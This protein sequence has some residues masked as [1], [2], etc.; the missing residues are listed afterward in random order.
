MSTNPYLAQL[1]GQ[2]AG[3]E[4]V[5][6][7]AF[8]KQANDEGLDLTRLPDEEVADLYENVFKPAKI[9]ELTQ[10]DATSDGLIEKA[11]SEGAS[12]EVLERLALAKLSGQAM[13]EGY[14]E[15]WEKFA[16]DAAAAEAAPEEAA[17]EGEG[18]GEEGVTEEEAKAIVDEAAEEAVEEAAAQAPADAAPEEVAAAAAEMV[19][20]KVEEKT[21]ELLMWKEAQK[22]GGKPGFLSR[23]GKKTYR[24]V[25]RP[26][27]RHIARHKLPYG[28]GAAAAGGL[29]AGYFG[30]KALQ[31]KGE[32][33]LSITDVV[34]VAAY[35]DY[36]LADPAEVEEFL[37]EAQKKGGKPGFLRR[38]GR[39][40]GEAAKAVGKHVAKHKLPYG[41][42]G[43]AAGGLAAGY[44]V[45][46]LRKKAE[47]YDLLS[48]ALGE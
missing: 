31:K 46:R 7:D 42:G 13:F 41:I 48:Q 29:T 12:D 18:G 16:Q 39:R 47:A 40:V 28:A 3:D 43:A 33:E 32:D 8:V 21:A 2:G 9:A 20:E 38:M 45:S 15:A 24:K 36:G 1:M 30:G 26:I 44:G 23:M 11:A 6:M 4:E 34:K 22:K 25:L 27:G 37:K 14:R 5:L 35:G 10:M 17:A 19:P